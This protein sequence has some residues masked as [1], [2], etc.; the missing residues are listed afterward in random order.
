MNKYYKDFIPTSRHDENSWE[1]AACLKICT[2]AACRKI[3]RS[4]QDEESNKSSESDVLI[5]PQ[6]MSPATAIACGL[7]YSTILQPQ[8]GV[9]YGNPISPFS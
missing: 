1:C 4:F 9:N 8:A 6:Q 5:D 2:C 3:Y 7:V